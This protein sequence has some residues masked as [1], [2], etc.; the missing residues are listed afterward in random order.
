MKKEVLALALSVS[1]LSSTSLESAAYQ[2]LESTPVALTPDIKPVPTPA[3]WKDIPVVSTGLPDELPPAVKAHEQNAVKVSL[4]PSLETRLAAGVTYKDS[5]S[6]VQIAEK[7]YLLAGHLL[8]KGDNTPEDGAED[9]ENLS[10]YASN[11]HTSITTIQADGSTI[12]ESGLGDMHPVD[13]AAG[14][15]KLHDFRVPDIALIRRTAD[16]N[17]HS[18]QSFETVTINNE[19]L[20]VGQPVFI[21]NYQPTANNSVRTPYKLLLTPEEIQQGLDRPAIYGGIIVSPMPDGTFLVAVGMKS[22]GAAYDI[23]G[24]GGSSGSGVYFEDGRLIGISVAGMVTPE[25]IAK[26][27]KFL[28]GTELAKDPYFALIQP[29]NEKM[30]GKLEQ[31]LRNDSICK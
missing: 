12:T 23:F 21:M 8:L 18:K 30:V 11:A 9:C 15:F 13:A 26:A 6:G 2:Q 22:Y 28:T 27:I 25:I 16:K 4:H 20:I 24:R 7:F 5:V 29:V 1:L 17:V 19:P 3:V 10:V 31:Q 14:S